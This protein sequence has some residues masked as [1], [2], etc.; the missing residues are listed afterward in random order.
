MIRMDIGNPTADMEAIKAR[1]DALP[2]HLARKHLVAVMR[3]LG[4]AGVPILKKHTPKQKNRLVLGRDVLTREYTARKVKGGSLRK[5]VTS[6]GKLSKDRKT[7]FGVVGFKMGMQ[8]RKAIW[9]HNGT[10]EAPRSD[11]FD[12][13][14]AAYK[15]PGLE[16]MKKAMAEGLEKAAAELAA[17]KNPG[18]R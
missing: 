13:F 14:M 7:A 17:G 2:R 1:F 11:F 12:R 16:L 3:R 4:K 6:R 10:A 5:A 18:R 9:L 15:G 8:S